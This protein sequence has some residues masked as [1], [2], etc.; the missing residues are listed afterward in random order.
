MNTGNVLSTFRERMMKKLRSIVLVLIFAFLL[1]GV[2]LLLLW[3]A[4]PFLPSEL[5]AR[6][7]IWGQK[8]L[9]SCR[10][11]VQEWFETLG[12]GG[13]AFFIGIQVLQVLV[14]PVPGQI[15]GLAGGF[16]FG[17]GT[18]LL[19]TMVGLGIGSLLAM[20]LGR[21]FGWHIVR[22]FVPSSVMER[23]DR[24]INDGG[25]FTF[26]MIFLLP[27]LPDDAVCFLAGLTRL[28]LS[29]LWI[30]CI[31]GRLPGMAVLSFAGAG[32]GGGGASGRIVFALAMALSLAVWL[33]D[34]EIERFAKRSF[35]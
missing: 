25:L 5:L 4:R 34:E 17:F 31:L 22:R 3:G 12:A 16:V 18:G 32:L 23:F 21:V 20:L 11:A 29:G 8:D 2:F 33:L 14:A 1:T 10:L 24:V 9:E 35:K 30:V 28:R 19:Y 15:A 6:L 13:P 7:E 27:A 26:F